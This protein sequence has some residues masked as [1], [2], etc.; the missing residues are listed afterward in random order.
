MELAI[1]GL[2]RIPDCFR[3]SEADVTLKRFYEHFTARR[4]VPADDLL[5]AV[6]GAAKRNK[7]QVGD[8]LSAGLGLATF[9][10]LNRKWDELARGRA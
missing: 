9:T 8:D 4:R 5:E 7:T 2:D 1:E 3:G 6:T 10:S